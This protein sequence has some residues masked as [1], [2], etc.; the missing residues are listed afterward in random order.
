MKKRVLKKSVVYSLYGLS[1]SLLLGGIVLLNVANPDKSLDSNQEHYSLVSRGLFDTVETV[2]NSKEKLIKPYIDEDIKIVK[3]YYDYL[4]DEETQ[5]GSLIYY[6]NTYLQSS[7][8]SYGREESFDVIAILDG[9]IKEVK[10]DTTLGNVIIV[11]HSNNIISTYQSLTDIKVK[12]GDKVSQGDI[13][14]KSG[15][16]NI[17]S[18]LNNHLY[19]ELAVNGI[20]VNPENYYNKSIDEL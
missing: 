7:G 4:A 12:Q 1:F 2:V 14:A 15:T 9:T 3:N 18:D 11:E 10:E 5:K 13:I 20:T 19:F 17:S 8:V 6:E 16:S